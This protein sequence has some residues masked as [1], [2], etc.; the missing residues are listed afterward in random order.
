MNFFI[1][2]LL[3]GIGGAITGFL[4]AHHER[5]LISDLKKKGLTVLLIIVLIAAIYVLA[6]H[7]NDYLWQGR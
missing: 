4:H 5:A 6:D 1:G 2:V 3:W 7:Y